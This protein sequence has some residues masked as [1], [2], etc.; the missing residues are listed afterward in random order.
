MYKNQVNCGSEIIT[1]PNLHRER[2]VFKNKSSTGGGY[3]YK[4]MCTKTKRSGSAAPSRA[5]EY[6]LAFLDSFTLGLNPFSFIFDSLAPGPG[7]SSERESRSSL[8]PRCLCSP[9]SSGKVDVSV[10]AGANVLE[11]LDSP[12][13]AAV[14]RHVPN[15][16]LS[17]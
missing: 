2:Q 6:V 11:P 10:W 15:G 7:G 4:T 1:K 8:P 16:R 9:G 14:W 3:E 13:R 17:R 12:S 5:L